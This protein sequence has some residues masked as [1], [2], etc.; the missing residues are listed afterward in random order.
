MV[1]P[2]KSLVGYVERFL[3]LRDVSVAY[4]T[5]LRTRCKHFVKWR[6][7]AVRIADLNCD[8]VNAW[9]AAL[10]TQ[11]LHPE[12][13]DGYRR[14]LLAIWRDAYSEGFNNNPPLRIR[15]IKKPR[16]VIY[17][18][19]HA[20]LQQLLHAARKLRGWHRNGNR[21]AVFWMA[22]I[23]SA[24]STGLRRGD[25]LLVFRDQIAANGTTTI[26]QHKTDIQVRVK[27]S[28]EALKWAMQLKCPNGLLL[29]WPYRKDALPPRFQALKKMA[30][31][32]RGTLKWIRRSAGSHAERDNP[33]DGPRLLGHS[34]EVFR[35]SYEDQS[36]TERKP[37]EPPPL[38]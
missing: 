8:D 10:Q 33:G 18:Y 13:V 14:N 17:A 37:P 7:R 16:R 1:A 20:E 2:E 19:S 4:A 30:G 32:K 12:T 29:P 25:L 34:P 9:L 27:F 26:I 22:L 23:H 28:A 3:S 35:A 24:Y 15:K 6:K 5:L 11:S 21:R 38:P 36:I 31:V